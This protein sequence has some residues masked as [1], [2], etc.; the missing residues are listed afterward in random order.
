MAGSFCNFINIGRGDVD[1]MFKMKVN[2]RTDAR[3]HVLTREN[4]P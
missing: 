4:G 1:K 2:A 3:K